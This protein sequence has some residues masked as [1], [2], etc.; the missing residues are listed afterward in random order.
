MTITTNSNEPEIVSGN[1]K[2]NISV[3]KTDISK[4]TFIHCGILGNIT[5]IILKVRSYGTLQ[6]L[7]KGHYILIGNIN[8][9][10]YF[11]KTKR[12]KI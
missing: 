12:N 2:I 1:C 8:T 3:I 9:K 7:N 10:L 6:K 11:K 5:Y 4:A